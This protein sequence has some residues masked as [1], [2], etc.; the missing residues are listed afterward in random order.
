MQQSA[1]GLA[2]REDCHTPHNRLDR[3]RIDN[4]L[5]DTGDEKRRLAAF[6]VVVEVDEEG[7]EGGLAS[8]RGRGVVLV[9]V[10]CGV[11]AGGGP[12]TV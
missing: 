9:G 4:A 2:V 3:V 10:C 12:C 7:E 1:L 11:D 5:L 6:E 8:V